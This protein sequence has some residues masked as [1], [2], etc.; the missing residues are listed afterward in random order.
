MLQGRD[1][2]TGKGTK[3]SGLTRIFYPVHPLVNQVAAVASMLEHWRRQVTLQFA[4]LDARILRAAAISEAQ[5]Y[6]EVN[7]PFGQEQAAMVFFRRVA[8]V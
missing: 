4:Q 7:K 8:R 1:R 3:F 6:I 5:R 2:V